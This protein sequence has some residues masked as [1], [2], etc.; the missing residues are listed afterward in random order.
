MGHGITTTDNV[1][2]VRAPMWHGLGT[3]LEGY[4]TVQEARELVHPWEPVTEP[5]YRRSYAMDEQG[6]PTEYMEAV[7]GWQANVR[8]DNDD[9]LGITRDTYEP[10]KNEVMYEIAS[11]LEGEARGRVMLETGGSLNGGAK[12]WLLMRFHEPLQVNSRGVKKESTTTIPYFTLQ[13]AHDGSASFRGQ[14]TM[15]RIVCQ[16]TAHMADMDARARGTEFTF[17]HSKN[18]HDRIEEA[19]KALAGW[20]NSVEEYQRFSE[21]LLNVPVTWAQAVEFRERF[22]PEP[23]GDVI[24]DRVRNN[25]HEARDVWTDFYHDSDTSDGI[26]GTA[27]GLLHASVEYLN[28]ARKAHTQETRFRRTFLDRDRLTQDATKLVLEVAGA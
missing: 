5:L 28:H 14:A 15:T 25:I 12:V 23:M 6:N 24:T 18:V 20:Q 16:N 11:A 1:F 10:V 4:P 13:N 7:E 8:S 26:E 3:I 19:R 17:R 27:Y 9:L 21:H 2:S 22:F